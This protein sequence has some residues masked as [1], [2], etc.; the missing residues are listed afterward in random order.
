VTGKDLVPRP[1]SN[2][3][4]PEADASPCPRFDRAVYAALADVKAT[5]LDHEVPPLERDAH[6]EVTA[7]KLRRLV[8]KA[9]NGL[10]SEVLPEPEPLEGSVEDAPTVKIPKSILDMSD[11]EFDAHWSEHERR[12]KADFQSRVNQI[13][14]QE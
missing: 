14:E 5:A 9:E 2:V 13:M 10:W 3:A 1:S 12:I 7:G 8:E 4:V 6:R 11:A